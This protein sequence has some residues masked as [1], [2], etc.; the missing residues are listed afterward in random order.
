MLEENFADKIWLPKI[1]ANWRDV[2]RALRT[3]SSKP[4]IILK[5]GVKVFVTEWM[6]DFL[7]FFDFKEIFFEQVYLENGFYTPSSNHTIVDIG[8]HMGLFPLF[9]QT[10]VSQGVKVHCFE[11]FDENI[12]YINKNI[13]ENNLQDFIKVYPY[14][15]WDKKT[16]K[17]LK[18]GASP[19]S[20][21]FFQE[22]KDKKREKYLKQPYKVNCI[23]LN[24][25]FAM[26]K[27]EHVDFLKVHC[28]GSEMK[29]LEGASSETM[30][31]IDK[32]V[33]VYHERVNPENYTVIKQ[34]LEKHNFEIKSANKYGRLYKG[35]DTI[36]DDAGRIWAEN[37]TSKLN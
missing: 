31:K 18:Y 29:V 20:L 19:L 30:S 33:V 17:E 11:P 6:Y 2:S 22:M 4:P 23:S 26:A 16:T 35:D 9:C 12:E 32:I 36:E 7:I 13:V 1:C 25:A 34:L 15:I 14:A 8:T 37:K 3:N 28:E 21:S 10:Q 24:E 5:N 27:V